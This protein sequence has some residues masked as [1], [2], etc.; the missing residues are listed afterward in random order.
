TGAMATPRAAFRC[1]SSQLTTLSTCIPYVQ[2]N[3]NIPTKDCYNGLLK[4]HKNTRKCLCVLIKENTDPQLGITIN[5]T[6]ALLL[7]KFYCTCLQT[8]LELRSLT[9]P[10]PLLHW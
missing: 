8:L 4:L 3:A 1:S 2:G 9:A 5:V 7:P 6:M 10:L